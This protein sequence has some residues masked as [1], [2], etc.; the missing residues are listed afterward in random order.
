MFEI[1]FEKGNLSK[2]M[3]QKWPKWGSGA[4]QEPN[5]DQNRSRTPGVKINHFILDVILEPVW[6]LKFDR[7][8]VVFWKGPFWHFGRH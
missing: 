2:N 3:T 5:G 6:P 7:F 4:G 1:P 8:F